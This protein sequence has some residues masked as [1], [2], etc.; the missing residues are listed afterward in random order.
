[1]RRT[2]RPPVCRSRRRR[3]RRRCIVFLPVFSYYKL[4]LIV[5]RPCRSR[6]FTRSP[7]SRRPRDI[8]AGR[9]RIIA[10]SERRPGKTRQDIAFWRWFSRNY[11]NRCCSIFFFFF[12]FR[13]LFRRQTITVLS[14]LFF[15]VSFFLFHIFALNTFYGI[16]ADRTNTV[17][18]TST[19]LKSTSKIGSFLPRWKKNQEFISV[20]ILIF[21]IN[22]IFYNSTFINRISYK[23]EKG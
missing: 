10:R 4:L 12:I 9:E 11:S 16:T 2:L 20:F 15:S 13:P 18:L 23:I 17:D 7:T 3:R 22:I 6:V 1:M 21:N 14:A 8:L 19:R 5:L